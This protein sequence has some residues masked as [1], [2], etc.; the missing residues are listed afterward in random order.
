MLTKYEIRV[1]EHETFIMGT[2]RYF[3]FHALSIL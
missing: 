3:L 1:Y 2:F